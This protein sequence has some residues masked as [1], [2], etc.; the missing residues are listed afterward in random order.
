MKIKEGGRQNL[1]GEG[2]GEIS[3][4]SSMTQPGGNGR[5]RKSKFGG[6]GS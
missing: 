1:E 5:K 4:G 3:R 2:K 6:E